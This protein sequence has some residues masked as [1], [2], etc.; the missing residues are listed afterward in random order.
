MYRYGAN[1]TFVIHPGTTH[2]VAKL[3]L[4]LAHARSV[5]PTGT[6]VM[7]YEITAEDSQNH[8]IECIDQSR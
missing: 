3:D 5:M 1:S 8:R 6:V 2:E 7:E 4:G